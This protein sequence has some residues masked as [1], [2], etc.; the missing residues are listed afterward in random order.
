MPHKRMA[1]LVVGNRP[2]LVLGDDAALALGAGD[3]A[4]HGLLDLFLRDLLFAAAGCQKRSFVHEVGKVGTRK[5]GREAR[6]ARKVDVIGKRLVLCVHGKDFLAPTHV[7]T[8]DRDLAVKTPRTQK[9]WVEDVGAVGCRDENRCALVF[10]AIHLNQQLVQSLFALVMPATEARATLATHGVDLVDE[11]DRRGNLFGLLEEVAHAAGSHTHEHLDKVGTRNREEGHAGL[12]RNGLGKKRLACSR[13]ANQKHAA[14]DLCA[15]LLIA[16][17][18]GEEVF[19]LLELLNGLVDARHLI[20]L[21][22]GARLFRRDGARGAEAHLPR[23]LLAHPAHVK[24]EDA[25]QKQGRAHG[26]EQ[27]PPD[28]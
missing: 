23:V 7:G 25:H 20:E 22:G 27:G 6:D 21:G 10:E 8:V 12:A 3:D 9:R 24:H 15:H 11:D 14:R 17:G 5:A 18:L 13:R 16:F 2:P 4:L 1:A 19:D 28:I 26:D